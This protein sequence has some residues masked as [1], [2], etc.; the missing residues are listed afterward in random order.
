MSFF[1][2]IICHSS[3]YNSIISCSCNFFINFSTYSSFLLYLLIFSSSISGTISSTSAEP[4]ITEVAVGSAFMQ[5]QLFDYYHNAHDRRPA[6]Y[7][8]LPV[9][10][11]ASEGNIYLPTLCCSRLLPS[12][13]LA[14][15]SHFA[16]RKSFY[17]SSDSAPFLFQTRPPLLS[18][19][20][21]AQYPLL[22]K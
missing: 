7:F 3:S 4:S 12:F 8:V 21:A 13:L 15:S 17:I 10:R 6:C 5:S 1:I 9:T 16:I 18:S 20:E 2:I 11:L 19:L 14:S 22:K